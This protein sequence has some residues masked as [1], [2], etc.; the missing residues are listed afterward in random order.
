VPASLRNSRKRARSRPCPLHCAIL[1]VVRFL[2]TWWG[3]SARGARAGAFQHM[4][5]FAARVLL[6]IVAELSDE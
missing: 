1:V 5:G 3:F 6:N 2:S 4:L